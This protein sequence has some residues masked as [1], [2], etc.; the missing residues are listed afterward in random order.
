MQLFS[1]N[2][3]VNADWF[4]VVVQFSVLFVFLQLSFLLLELV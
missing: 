2:I 3:V 1:F 4:S